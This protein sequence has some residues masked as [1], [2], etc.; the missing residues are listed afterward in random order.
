MLKADQAKCPHTH[1]HKRQWW[2]RCM[3]AW[4][5]GFA[6][7]HY[8][9]QNPCNS[10]LELRAQCLPYMESTELWGVARILQ[11]PVSLPC[12]QMFRHYCGL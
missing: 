2:L 12:M 3:H 7:L 1:P 4:G 11:N 8:I 6:R 5:S 9:N 10:A